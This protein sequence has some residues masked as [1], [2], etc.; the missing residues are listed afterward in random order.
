M[1]KLPSISG[2]E[3]IK[4]LQKA[5]FEIRRV[6]GSHYILFNPT[7]K[8]IVTVPYHKTLKK[9]TLLNIIRQSG[10]SRNEFLALL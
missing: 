9:G 5:G 1:T 3:A 2:K 10:L 7:T 4:A 8:K 6:T